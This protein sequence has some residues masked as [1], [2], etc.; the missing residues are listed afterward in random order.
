MPSGELQLDESFL[1]LSWSD[2]LL[3]CY[4]KAVEMLLDRSLVEHVLVESFAR[5]RAAQEAYPFVRPAE[6]RPGGVGR[7]GEHPL[8]HAALVL[9]LE[10]ALEPELKTNIRARRP[11]KAVRRNLQRYLFRT[12]LP[13]DR[14][15]LIRDLETRAAI[16]ALRPLLALDYALLIQRRAGGG[17]DRLNYALTHFHVMIDEVLDRTI[18]AFGL[19]LR[20]LAGH[21]F[22]QG[23]E[24]AALLEEKFYELY[25]MKSTAAGRRTAALVAHNVLLD[26]PGLH[27]VYVGST[28]ARSL[29]KILKNDCI[30]RWVLVELDDALREQLDREHGVAGERLAEAYCIPDSD[31]GAA[32]LAVH[33][34]PTE[35]GRPPA[36]RKMR[37][38]INL[39]ERWTSIDQQVLLPLPSSPEAR[40]L[41]VSWVY[42]GA[43]G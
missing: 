2:Q 34:R 36:D 29:S 12:G 24:Y 8:H 26:N 28:E 10:Q 30:T 27:A 15:A 19:R 32:V 5:F 9:L 22:E 16:D 21:L 23:E 37:R 6:L 14:I 38:V 31:P 7:T 13:L 35:H 20:Y 3:R 40:P 25:G 18:E 42:R 43:K 33:Y 11:Q 17:K 39:S 4:F 1:Q 41:P